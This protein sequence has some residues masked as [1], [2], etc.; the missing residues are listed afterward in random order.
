MKTYKIDLDD[1]GT[2][3]VE[4]P[5][6]EWVENY[7]AGNEVLDETG[8]LYLSEGMFILPDGTIEGEEDEDIA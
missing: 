4:N 8:K 5:S 2:L 3:V 1:G 7:E 6:T